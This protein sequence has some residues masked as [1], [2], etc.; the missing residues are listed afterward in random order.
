VTLST[1]KSTL[2]V[3]VRIKLL[4]ISHWP[5]A[6]VLQA[7]APLVPLLQ[8]PATKALATGFSSTSWTVTV[9]IAVQRPVGP[10]TL[11]PSKS[12]LWMLAPGIGVAVG[13]GVGGGGP[14][15]ETVMAVPSL[16]P[17]GS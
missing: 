1:E 16:S 5:L 14:N 15:C 11:L 4:R 12:P 10:G 3:A 13:V 17:S 9:T 8:L 6:S 7:P 2:P